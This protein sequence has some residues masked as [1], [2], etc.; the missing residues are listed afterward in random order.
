MIARVNTYIS[1]ITQHT[2]R[3]KILIPLMVLSAIILTSCDRDKNNP[4]YDYFPDMAYSKAYESYAPNPNYSDGK[5]LQ[6]PVDGTVSRDDEVY[7]Y[8]KTDEDLLK[9]TKWVN[10]LTPDSVNLGRG[11]V[12][13]QNI[14]LHCHGASGNGKGHLFTSGKYPFPP[15]NLLTPKAKA[16]TDGQIFH[17]ISVGIG[18][19]PPHAIIVRPDDRWK[20]VMYVRSLQSRAP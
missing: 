15:A 3:G 16:Y 4:G 20:T 18:I 5:T 7:P 6:T 12:V 19:M 11:K 8:K 13:Y 9:A 1:S 2:Q 14:C 10:P 17:I